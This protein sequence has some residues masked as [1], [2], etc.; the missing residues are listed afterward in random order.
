MGGYDKKIP[1]EPM[2]KTVCEKVKVMILMGLT[3]PKIEAAITS[4]PD[5]KEGYPVIVHAESMEDAVEKARE[6]AEKGDIVTLSP[7][8]ASFDLYPNFEVRGNHY[9]GLVKELESK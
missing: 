1:F 7:A 9:K 5:Y 6:I 8:C 3:A 4:C 2:A